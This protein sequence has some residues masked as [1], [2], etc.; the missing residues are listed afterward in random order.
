M[1]QIDFTFSDLLAGRITRSDPGARTFTLKTP[2][3][4]EFDVKVTEATYAEGPRNLGDGWVDGS[5]QMNR[6]TPGLF[7]FAYG[8]FYPEGGDHKF[9]AKHLVFPTRE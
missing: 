8:I 5:D 1:N 2:G 7:C 9:E 3:G 6:L 4:S